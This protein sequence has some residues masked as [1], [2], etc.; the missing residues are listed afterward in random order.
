[1]VL[2]LSQ[3]SFAALVVGLAVLAALRWS[4]KPV[5]AAILAAVL[6]SA[7]VV[8]LAGKAIG[9]DVRSER[10]LDR[11][12][13][14]RVDL[15]KGAARMVGDRPG[16]GFGSGSFAERF[17]AR[18]DVRSERA[19]AASHTTPLTITAEQ[20]V[21]GL[22]LY[23]FLVWAAFAVLFSGVRGAVRR[24][25]AGV[26]TVA[27]AAVAAAFCGLVLHTLVYAAFLEDP[28]AWVLLA[29][30]AALRAGASRADDEALTGDADGARTM[31]ACSL[32]PAG[33][34]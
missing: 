14:G 5:L 9:V 32:A 13:S 7:V 18:E 21:I 30:A 3:S 8:L 11:A 15:I 6:L 29:V 26:V 10:A 34:G 24:R 22:A 27:R 12:S 19:A 16:W 2:S 31:A 4:V 17:R 28:L 25:Q 1:M 33:R 20:G 23:L